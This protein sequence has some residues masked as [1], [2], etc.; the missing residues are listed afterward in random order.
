[1]DDIPT[2]L[3]VDILQRLPWTSRRRLRLVCRSWRDLVHQQTTE[4]QQRRDAVPL[5][6]TSESAYVVDIA[7]PEEESSSITCAL[8]ELHL[9]G[10]GGRRYLERMEVVGV[11]N[12]VLCLCD[13]SKPAGAVTLANP[14]TGD[15][16]PLP[17]IPRDGLFRRHNTRRSGRSWHQA[18]SF[19]FHRGTG[20]YK[21]VHVPCFFKTKVTL[22]VFTLG[23]ASWREVPAPAYAACNLDAGVVSVDGATYWATEG[24]GDR[25]MCLDLESER[26]TCAP[27]LP[28]SARPICRLT[29]VN[30]R[31]G[32][33]TTA[34]RPP[35]H[36]YGS[37]QVWGLEG[38]R[39]NEQTWV[40]LYRLTSCLYGPE[41][42]MARPYLIHGEY[43]LLTDGGDRLVLRRHQPINYYYGRRSS[44]CTAVH[45]NACDQ[46]TILSDMRGRIRRTFAYL[47]TEEALSVHRRW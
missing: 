39:R 44:E 5:V 16:L 41:Q 11:C 30:R 42:E 25:I 37:I 7:D 26:V 46:T 45:D 29:Q 2:E 43:V 40:H 24:S 33:A 13:D 19:G 14:A 12:G 17:P 35:Y 23:E 6:V 15:V 8:R 31:L 32:A 27:P 38:R 28:A 4:M 21:V 3:V 36:G 20:Q 22:Q 18:Y 10:G 34:Y 47:K 1:M 9:G